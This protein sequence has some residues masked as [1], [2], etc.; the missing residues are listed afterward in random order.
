MWNFVFFFQKKNHKCVFICCFFHS[1]RLSYWPSDPRVPYRNYF[2]C[3]S[4]TLAL[5]TKVFK[6]TPSQLTKSF[7]KVLVIVSKCKVTFWQ[8]MKWDVIFL[9]KKVDFLYYRR[10]SC[11]WS[12]EFI[13]IMRGLIQTE[14][15]SSSALFKWP[16]DWRATN[17]PPTPFPP[18]S[19]YKIFWDIH[20]VHHSWKAQ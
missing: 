11:L 8:I 12:H 18:K 20:F 6:F 5:F 4:S 14:I 10:K 13:I 2:M 9:K 3:P 15:K 7:E 16:K 17:P 19:Y 1:Q